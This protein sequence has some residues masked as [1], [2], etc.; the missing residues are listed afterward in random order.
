[1]SRIRIPKLLEHDETF[2]SST[3]CRISIS[4]FITHTSLKQNLS[5]TNH[6]PEHLGMEKL[7]V[8]QSEQCTFAKSLVTV[9]F[10]DRDVFASEPILSVS[11]VQFRHVFIKIEN[12]NEF[13]QRNHY[14]NDRIDF[15]PAT[16][17]TV[18]F[19][20]TKLSVWFRTI[21]FGSVKWSQ[22]FFRNMYRSRFFYKFW[23]I[24]S[25]LARFRI[26][27]K[28]DVLYTLRPISVHFLSLLGC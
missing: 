12:S 16:F 27:L 2:H 11:Y 9:R 14:G 4:R 1:M 8:A 17:R 3:K 15:V 5:S 7:P 28:V 25:V 23:V 24:N 18:H 22:S 6:H 10:S 21:G 19:S 13:R 26:D 20:Y